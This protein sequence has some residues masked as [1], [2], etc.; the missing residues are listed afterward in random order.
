MGANPVRPAVEPA[1][2][3]VG[4]LREIVL[5]YSQ[6]SINDLVA[7]IVALG[8]SISHGMIVESYTYC[9][10]CKIRVKFAIAK[11]IVA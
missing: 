9:K 10:K 2:D 8:L 4:Y 7:R 5:C 11:I 1:S 3:R 6:K